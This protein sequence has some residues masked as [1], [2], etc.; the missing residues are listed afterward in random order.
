M[1]RLDERLHAVPLDR[2]Q[3]RQVLLNLI[4]NAIHAMPEGGT[5]EVGTSLGSKS[6]ELWVRDYGVGI[7]LTAHR[8]D[9]PAQRG[10]CWHTTSTWD[11]DKAR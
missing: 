3:M 4:I 7:E 9:N 2:E 1:T 8:R 6:V 11:R 10:P 5:V